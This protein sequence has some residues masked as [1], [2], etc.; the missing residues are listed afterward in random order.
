VVLEASFIEEKIV[1]LLHEIRVAEPSSV[2]A[3]VDF[4]EEFG[5]SRSF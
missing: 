3:N 2:P 1:D 4:G 5:I